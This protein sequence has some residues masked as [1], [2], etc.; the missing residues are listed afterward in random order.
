[1]RRI[2]SDF[3]FTTATNTKLMNI[4]D[5]FNH[6]AILRP[7]IAAFAKRSAHITLT[8]E[9]SGDASIPAEYADKPLSFFVNNGINL[10][11]GVS[12]DHRIEL[13]G[14]LYTQMGVD[15][16]TLVNFFK[17]VGARTNLE[18][19]R[20]RFPPAPPASILE[21][22]PTTTGAA[23]SSSSGSMNSNL[24]RSPKDESTSSFLATL[25]DQNTGGAANSPNEPSC[26]PPEIFFFCLSGLY[27]F[28][29]F[30]IVFL[31]HFCWFKFVILP[32]FYWLKY[33]FLP[34]LFWG[35]SIL[36][37]N[38]FFF[39]YRD[40]NFSDSCTGHSSIRSAAI[41]LPSE[42]KRPFFSRGS[43]LRRE[44]ISL[45]IFLRK[46]FPP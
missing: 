21:P 17:L 34:Y 27:N 41:S 20:D 24:V 26:L 3:S 35:K 29:L 13:A 39:F 33:V 10:F 6:M 45:S 31:I 32:Q 36:I 2:L 16:P 5:M 4:V 8:G 38:L 18:S 11:Q 14:Y 15:Q 25:S 30:C 46:L 12:R 22:Q 9:L 1:M 44:K 40:T 28:V 19:F 43:K 37:R 42:M 23:E 7:K